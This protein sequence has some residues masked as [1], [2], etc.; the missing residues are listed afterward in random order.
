MHRRTFITSSVA[1]LAALAG[2]GGETEY[3]DGN[4]DSGTAGETESSEDDGD[5]GETEESDT[6]IELLDHE[7]VR[8]SRES[9]DR[10][11]VHVEGTA[12]N[13]GDSQLSYAEIRV[14]WYDDEGNQLDSSLDNI[15]DL[16][17]GR[18]WKFEV[19]YLGDGR[20]VAEYDIAPG[21]E[22]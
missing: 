19:P 15:N 18:T 11:D 7:L 16:N 20:E 9:S 10:E 22:R 21:T 5:S 17:P 6:D 12:E 4:E 3:E 13:T 14:R 1:S 8:E 2:C